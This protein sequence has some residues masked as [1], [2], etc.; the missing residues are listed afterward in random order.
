[1]PFAGTRDVYSHGTGLGISR[2]PADGRG[3][4]AVR[5]FGFG[6]IVACGSTWEAETFFFSFFL[7]SSSSFLLCI[8]HSR[9]SMLLDF[10]TL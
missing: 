5:L 3:V 8:F 2:F 9:F 1:M 6:I 7:F 10:P 4:D